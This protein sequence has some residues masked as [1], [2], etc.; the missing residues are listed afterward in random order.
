MKAATLK[1]IFAKAKSLLDHMRVIGFLL[2]VWWAVD[3]AMTVKYDPLYSLFWFSN[4]LPLIVAIGFIFKS[5]IVMT[6]AAIA[7]LVTEPGWMADFISR[8]FFGTGLFPGPVTEY[9]FVNI[10]PGSF[11]FY[12]ELNHLVTLPL[13]LYGVFRLGVSALAYRLCMIYSFVFNSVTYFFT[14]AGANV[15]CVHFSC[16]AASGP[17]FV[18]QPYYYIVWMVLVGLIA[19]P[20][21][22][23]FIKL[24]ARRA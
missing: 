8:L 12:L 14:P 5:R 4:W 7:A 2:L 13:S 9:M 10:G 15:N 21:N 19:W 24:F 20:V 6:S 23:L 17:G 22:I 11:F 3:I 16:L 1:N 18:S